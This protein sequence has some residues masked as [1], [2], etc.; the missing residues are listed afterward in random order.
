MKVLVPYRKRYFVFLVICALLTVSGVIYASFGAEDEIRKLR[1]GPIWRIPS[2][3]YGRPLKLAPGMDINR[4]GLTGRLERLRYRSVP[5]VARPGDYHKSPGSLTLFIH[6]FTYMGERHPACRVKLLL[7][8]N[9]VTGVV[10][11]GGNEPLGSA[12]LEPEEIT[13]VFDDLSEDRTLVKLGDCPKALLDAIVC[14][15]DRRFYS[16]S[17]FDMRSMLRAGVS[18]LKHGAVT[19]GGST[20]TQQLVKNLF[21]NRKRVMSRKVKELWIAMAM[22]REYTKDQILEMYVN[23]IYMGSYNHAGVCGMGGAARVLFDKDVSDLSLAEAALMAGMIKA[24]NAYSPYKY[25]DKARAR[26]NLVLALMKDQ[27]KV[28]EKEYARARKAPLKVVPLKPRKRHAPYFVDYVLSLVQKQFPETALQQ[29]GYR[30]Y[31]TL[32][33][34]AQNTAETLLVRSLGGKDKGIDGA[35]VVA[36]PATGEILAMV[37]GKDYGAS[38]YNRAVSIRRQ[39]GSLA[40]PIVYYTALRSGYTLTTFLDDSPISIPQA[41]GTSWEPANY[42]KVPHGRVMLRDALANSYNL[43]AVRLGLGLGVPAVLLELNRVLPLGTANVNPSMLLGALDCSPME[44]SVLYSAFANGGRQVRPFSLRGV[45]DENGRLVQAYTAPAP[46]LALDPAAVYLLGDALRQVVVAG[47]A[48]DAKVYGMP[49]GVCG[50]TG[51]T[52]DNRDSWFVGFTPQLVVTVW[53]GA[54]KYRSIGYTGAAGAMPVAAGVLARLSPGASWPV[55]PGIV[56][57]TVDPQNG[58]LANY[59]TEGGITVPYLDGTQPA[60]VSDAVPEIPVV[61]EIPKVFD[62]L[63]GLFD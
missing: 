31:T 61:K 47:T 40:K 44:V 11:P 48:R 16:H 5:Q 54:D 27:G 1:E 29:G 60:E 9:R 10:R 3:I 20:I 39:V 32:D 41:D 50:K 56:V 26:R 55:P 49:P 58:K 34:H 30:I 35:V 8:G 46:A 36:D 14:T 18:N 24:P 23:E 62:Y 13:R 59:W 22:E 19:E 53:L 52:D 12:L 42:D 43:A 37:G 15:E 7:Q 6:E 33:M 28:S 4:T 51:T 38:Q 63:K 2:K 45:A 21:L 25:P 17:G 57:C